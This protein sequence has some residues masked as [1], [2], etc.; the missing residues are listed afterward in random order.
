MAIAVDGNW[1]AQSTGITADNMAESY[2]CMLLA[3]CG[4]FFASTRLRFLVVIFIL[5]L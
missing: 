5:H 2:R 4:Q 1:S 3:V